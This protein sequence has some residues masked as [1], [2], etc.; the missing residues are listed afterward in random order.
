[1]RRI[2]RAIG[3]IVAVV[4]IVFVVQIFASE[5]GE[6]VKITTVDAA[7]EHYETSVWVVDLDGHQW[8]RSGSAKSGWYTRLKETPTLELDRNGAHGEYI[9]AAESTQ[10]PTINA[11]MRQKYGWADAYIGLFFPRSHAVAIRLDPRPPEA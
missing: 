8:I 9:V 3:A 1:M 2:R 4:L 6:V 7:G 11:L 10:T 5:S